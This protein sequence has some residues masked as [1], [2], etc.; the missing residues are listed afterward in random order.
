MNSGH[1]AKQT[2]HRLA[3]ALAAITPCL[4]C[5]S[6]PPSLPAHFPRHRGMGG[7]HAGWATEEWVPLCFTCHEALDRRNGVSEDAARDTAFVTGI[8]R[9]RAPRWRDTMRQKEA[10]GE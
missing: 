6:P 2:A 4:V 1:R 7:G 3:T 8:V 5:Y 10:G 9:L